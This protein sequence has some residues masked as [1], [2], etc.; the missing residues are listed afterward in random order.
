MLLLELLSVNFNPHPL[1]RGRRQR[2]IKSK[3]LLHF[4]PHPLWRGRLDSYQLINGGFCISIH[5]LCEEG[6]RISKFTPL[7]PMIS[8]HTLCEEGDG[9]YH[10]ILLYSSVFQST[11]SVKRA[12]LTIQFIKK[13]QKISI[14]TLCEEG[15][16][17]PKYQV[18]EAPEFQSTPSVKRAT[19]DIKQTRQRLSYFNPHPLWRGRRSSARRATS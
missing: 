19:T 4:N 12:T 8:I 16:Y 1:W 15:D 18:C 13:S 6:D 2:A 5:T 14:H 11:P 9:H 7:I 10:Y 3:A 17:L